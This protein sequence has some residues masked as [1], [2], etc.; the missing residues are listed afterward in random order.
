MYG[1]QSQQ[2]GGEGDEEAQVFAH[3][4]LDVSDTQKHYSGIQVDQPVE[5]E[6]EEKI[7]QQLSHDMFYRHSQDASDH[8]TLCLDCLESDY[9]LTS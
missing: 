4:L 5:P 9:C 7:S 6:H 8:V 3:R 2:H 1:Y